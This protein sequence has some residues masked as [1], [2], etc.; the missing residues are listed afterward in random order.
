[1]RNAPSGFGNRTIAQRFNRFFAFVLSLT[2][3][4]SPLHLRQ[5]SIEQTFPLSR[6]HLLHRRFRIEFAA[7][8]PVSYM[9]EMYVLIRIAS[10]R[11]RFL[12]S[13]SWV[14]AASRSARRP[15]IDRGAHTRDRTDKSA[16]SAMQVIELRT[17]LGPEMVPVRRSINQPRRDRTSEAKNYS[18]NLICIIKSF[19][20]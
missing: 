16:P 6:I 3:P 15:T 14:F 7:R 1:M 11:I 12:H 13:R 20:A 2:S 4:F 9:L 8:Q 19:I 5:D 17:A 18:K 10:E